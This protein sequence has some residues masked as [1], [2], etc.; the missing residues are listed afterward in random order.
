MAKYD[1]KLKEK[2]LNLSDKVGIKSAAEQCNISVK[3]IT[4]WRYQRNKKAKAAQTKKP[5]D[6]KTSPIS[7]YCKELKNNPKITFQPA[8][9]K[10]R[11]F[12]RGEIYYVKN[13]YNI[14][15]EISKNRPAIIVSNNRLNSGNVIEIVY[16][17]TK[18]KSLSPEHI[19][20]KSSG[21]L[22]TALCEQITTVDVS[23]FC[24]LI[25]KCTPEEM[26]K[27]E[28]GILYSLGMEKY[29][30]ELMSDDQIVYRMNSIKAE[31][32]VYR[33]MYNELI[34]KMTSK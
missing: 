7:D 20:I 1:K 19:L 32:D 8:E 17:T 22:A 4:S 30:S 2:A 15:S 23:R 16:L 24:K 28:E 14:G 29:K 18:L 6:V 9:E 26:A 12:K 27:I 31:R 5:N 10:P 3:T 11:E 34:E 21:R 33:S 25:G 13:S